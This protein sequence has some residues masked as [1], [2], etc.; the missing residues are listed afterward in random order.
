MVGKALT[1]KNKDNTENI[2]PTRKNRNSLGD[3]SVKVT[4]TKILPDNENET[5]NDVNVVKDDGSK[6]TFISRSMYDKWKRDILQK[7]KEQ[8]SQMD[9][10]Q[11]S[12]T[13]G[14]KNVSQTKDFTFAV[15][16]NVLIVMA[17]HGKPQSA[18]ISL[19]SIESDT[20][21]DISFK[22]NL[23][24]S[25]M[26]YPALQFGGATSIPVNEF[27]ISKTPKKRVLDWKNADSLY[28]D[29]IK[30]AGCIDNEKY[31][32]KIKKGLE[33]CIISFE[34]AQKD[35]LF[36]VYFLRQ[37]LS[38]PCLLIPTSQL[39]NINCYRIINNKSEEKYAKIIDKDVNSYLCIGSD[40]SIRVLSGLETAY[41]YRGI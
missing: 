28:S 17:I 26:T 14:G 20:P 38:D 25:P 1:L 12:V 2:K 21:N 41:Q 11:K 4:V 35:F 3:S 37:P 36:D 40:K 5:N 13:S 27:R 34:K 24:I 30:Y 23:H 15:K 8:I 9:T 22:H 16:D 33:K 29:W 32:N 7:Y 39:G 6:S 19:H 31:N 10:L 18:P